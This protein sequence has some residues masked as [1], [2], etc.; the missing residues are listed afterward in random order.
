MPVVCVAEAW[1][2]V[3]MAEALPVV[4]MAEAGACSLYG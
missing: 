1:P 4:C 3:C 2:V